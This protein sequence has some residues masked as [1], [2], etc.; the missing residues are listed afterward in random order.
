MERQTH[1][2]VVLLLAVSLFAPQPCLAASAAGQDRSP[3]PAAQKPHPINPDDVGGP[4]G[5]VFM[6][7]QQRRSSE[8]TGG[9][10]GTGVI[11][12]GAVVDRAG[13]ALAQ[14]NVKAISADDP[15]QRPWVTA[16]DTN[17]RFQ[18][19]YLPVGR[20][21]VEV[22]HSGFQSDRRLGLKLDSLLCSIRIPLSAGSP[23]TVV[24]THFVELRGKVVE[25]GGDPIAGAQVE[26][27]GG[28]LANALSVLTD[29]EGEFRVPN[30]PSGVYGIRVMAHGF[31]PLEKPNLEIKP[32]PESKPVGLKLEL[33]KR[34]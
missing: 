17:G 29:A 26:L 22:S 28:S 5:T 25:S 34:Q 23:E 4:R 10:R 31:A 33:S 32:D 11:L 8:M 13:V 9:S 18:F 6:K 12:R 16:T 21:T 2:V 3:Q 20:Y 19:N 24:T 14:A 1:G 27:T 30:F 15:Q 7:G